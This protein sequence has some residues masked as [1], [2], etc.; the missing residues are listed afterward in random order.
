MIDRD[1]AHSIIRLPADA[2]RVVQVRA[3]R[4]IYDCPA[5][6]QDDSVTR[7][8]IGEIADFDTC[9]MAGD[10]SQG[11]L[12]IEFEGER[13]LVVDPDEVEP[14]AARRYRSARSSS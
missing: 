1:K 13:V 9:G 3:L 5:S 2:A 4:R 6:R 11:V 8:T 14:V 12:I 10:G 7:G